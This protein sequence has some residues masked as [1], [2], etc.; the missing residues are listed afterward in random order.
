MLFSTLSALILAATASAHIVISYPGWRGNNLITNETFPYGMQW[1][2]PCGGMGV[3]KNRTYWP[4]TGGALSFQPGWFQ[5][6]AQAF[7]YAN[8]GFGTEGP[9]GGPI[10]MSFPMVPVFQI[11]GP[12][13]NPYPGTVCLPQVPLPANTTVKPGDHATIQ[14]VELA[15]HGAALFSCVDIEFAEP[16]DPK[17]GKVNETNCYNST[18]IGF[19]DVYTITTKESGGDFVTGTSAAAGPLSAW[20]TA[21]WA[22]LLVGALWAVL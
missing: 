18:D 5:G 11:L 6:H 13:K 8:M 12:S 1:T 10:N 17:I 20:S 21:G 7:M 14:I 4:T 22:P 15:A 3:T 9:D 19:A 2:Y 16:G